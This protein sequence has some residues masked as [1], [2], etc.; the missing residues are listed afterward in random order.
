MPCF[1]GKEMVLLPIEQG[2]TER[3]QEGPSVRKDRHLSTAIF[4]E[5]IPSAARAAVTF[6]CGSI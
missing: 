6:F 2:K 3:H 4:G 1:S 5:I